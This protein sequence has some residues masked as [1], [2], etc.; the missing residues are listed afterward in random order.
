MRATLAHSMFDSDR[1]PNAFPSASDLNALK[2][3]LS[4]VLSIEGEGA[5]RVF[6]AARDTRL[7]MLTSRLS[8]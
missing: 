6:V 2:S 5:S 7:R 1:A 8:G 4:T 3:L